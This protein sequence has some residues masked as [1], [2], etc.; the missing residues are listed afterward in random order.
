MTT[1]CFCWPFCPKPIPEDLYEKSVTIR[2]LPTVPET[3]TT[4]NRTVA[5]SHVRFAS[6]EQVSL[7]T[8]LK[9]LPPR[10][11]GRAS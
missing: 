8:A 10:E 2:P 5:I 9:T 11:V 7:T 4:V 3:S 6:T 1:G